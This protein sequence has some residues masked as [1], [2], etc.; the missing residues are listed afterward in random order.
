MKG[1][2]FMLNSK[3]YFPS[4]IL[5]SKIS[6]LDFFS[7]ILLV[8]ISLIPLYV[9]FLVEIF[10]FLLIYPFLFLFN[11]KKG[12]FFSSFLLVIVAIIFDCFFISN[13]LIHKVNQLDKKYENNIYSLCTEKSFPKCI[14]I[15]SYKKTD[16]GCL[17]YKT[18][19][20]EGQVCG[21]Y[22]IQTK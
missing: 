13:F 16:N 11:L 17:E 4:M 5:I 1:F 19:K 21:N 20:G 12:L 14:P 2:Y 15:I 10:V 8:L 18:N 7:K 6:N 22:D 9:L 3:I